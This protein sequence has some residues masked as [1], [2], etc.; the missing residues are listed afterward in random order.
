MEPYCK[1]LPLFSALN[2]TTTKKKGFLST[3]SVY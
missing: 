1:A 2:I 3:K